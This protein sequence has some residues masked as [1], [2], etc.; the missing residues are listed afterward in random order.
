MTLGVG[1][2]RIEELLAISRLDPNIRAFNRLSLGVLNDPLNAC[3]SSPGARTTKEEP[4]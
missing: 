3:W 2:D 1:L 4:Y